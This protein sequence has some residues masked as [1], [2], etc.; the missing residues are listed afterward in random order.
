[1]ENVKQNLSVYAEFKIMEFDVTFVD[2]NGNV[3]K[4]ETVKQNI[5]QI[6]TEYNLFKITLP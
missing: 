6:R 1:M 4:T 3:L 5:T 2:Y